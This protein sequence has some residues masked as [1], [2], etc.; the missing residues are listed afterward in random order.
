M[1]D[2][3][4]DWENEDFTPQLPPAAAAAPAKEYETKGQ[5]LLSDEPDASK[6]ADEDKEL[7]E[8]KHVV[9]ASQVS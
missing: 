5:A 1:A 9:P 8:K 6:F 3:W 7:E 2:D 4:E